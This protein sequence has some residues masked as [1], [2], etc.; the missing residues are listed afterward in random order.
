MSL[1]RHVLHCAV[2][3]ILMTVI[4]SEIDSERAFINPYQFSVFTVRYTWKLMV[5]ACLYFSSLPVFEPSNV[6]L[7]YLCHI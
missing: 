2:R 1:F 4:L 5:D 3:L 6:I 7:T